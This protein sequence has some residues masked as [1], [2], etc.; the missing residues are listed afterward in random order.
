MAR[1]VNCLVLDEPTNHLDL[2]AIGQ[3]EAALEG[4]DGTLVLVTHD[5]QLLDAVR[6]DRT[7]AL[8]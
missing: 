1:G 3:L 8:G 7:L 2:A 6:I 5:R 4:Y